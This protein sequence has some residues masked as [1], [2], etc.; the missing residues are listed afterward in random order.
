MM[1]LEFSI[2]LLVTLKNFFLVCSM[3]F[4]TAKLPQSANVKGALGLSAP[5]MK[6]MAYFGILLW[7]QWKG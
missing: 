4:E 1:K 7:V 6:K 5:W 3:M 2:T